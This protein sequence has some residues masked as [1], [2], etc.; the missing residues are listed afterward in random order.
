VLSN[1]LYT[2]RFA[3]DTIVTTG[4]AKAITDFAFNDDDKRS[5][6]I[7][8]CSTVEDC[9][10]FVDNYLKLFFT[11]EPPNVGSLKGQ[12]IDIIMIYVKSVPQVDIEGL[13]ASMEKFNIEAKLDK[14]A[15]K[16][17]HLKDATGSKPR[18]LCLVLPN[19]ADAS[20]E[21][22][23]G[24]AALIHFASVLLGVPSGCVRIQLDESLGTACTYSKTIEEAM[25]QMVAVAKSTT[26]TVGQKLY[27]LVLRKADEK[28]KQAKISISA[29]AESLLVYLKILKRDLPL[30]RSQRGVSAVSM[31]KCKDMLDNV[32]RLSELGTNMSWTK[33]FIRQVLNE[34]SSDN[35][36]LPAAYYRLA[37]AHSNAKSNR[38][39]IYKLGYEPIGP[40]PEKVTKVFTSKYSVKAG[41]ISGVA[42]PGKE[43]LFER[44]RFFEAGAKLLLP[45]LE[46]DQR[47]K[48]ADQIRVGHTRLDRK[49]RM[50]YKKHTECIDELNKSYAIL[51]AAQSTANKKTGPQHACAARGNAANII[52]KHMKYQDYTGIEY[53]DYLDI[54]EPVRRALESKL[55]RKI[56][57]ARKKASSDPKD[58]TN[59]RK[60]P[61][62]SQK[63]PNDGDGE[64]SPPSPKTGT[65]LDAGAGGGGRPEGPPPP[66]RRRGDDD[67]M[68][69]SS[70]SLPGGVD[71]D[72]Q[73]C[74]SLSKSR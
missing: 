56:S 43:E 58:G 30:H 12:M 53:P 35:N 33:N 6:G 54:P 23:G 29:S 37:G 61:S 15:R 38:S 74:K 50:F 7:V 25:K 63:D 57:V 31:Q 14:R 3:A 44:D 70:V 26:G 46:V 45:Y 19:V 59:K 71:P 1:L 13:K 16:L 11:S 65:D 21:V 73:F 69:V 20:D 2:V 34:A 64:P 62:G 40:S 60:D 10:K 48:L 24:A 8:D 51:L 28:K 4:I 42:D 17:V 36:V 47:I 68:S 32:F 39:I 27:E 5:A 55:R 66:R 72:S 49:N 52:N 41:K 18:E 9:E 22:K 67:E